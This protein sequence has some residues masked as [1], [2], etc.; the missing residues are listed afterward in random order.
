MS[1]LKK[2]VKSCDEFSPGWLK[3]EIQTELYEICD[4][5]HSSCYNDCPVY[6]ING[7]PL[8]P[9]GEDGCT[10]FKDGKAMY[11]FIRRS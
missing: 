2:L 1:D 5:V 9:T 6:D 10:C 8:D 4:R 3:K 11:D 7:G